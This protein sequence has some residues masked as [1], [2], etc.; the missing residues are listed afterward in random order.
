M[1]LTYRPYIRDSAFRDFSI[2][3]PSIDISGYKPKY[4]KVDKEGVKEVKESPVK[5]EIQEINTEARVNKPPRFKESFHSKNDFI[6]TMI[7][8]YET[9][10]R[11]KGINP[12]FAKSLVAQDGLESAWGSKP[13]GRYNFGGIKG[14]GTIKKTREVINGNNIYLNDSFKDFNSLED[15]ANYK[16]DLL[17]NSRYKVFSGGVNDF[18]SKVHNGGYATDPNYSRILNN[19]ISSFKFGGVFKFQNGGIAEGKEWVKN[20]YKNRRKL[21]KNNIQRTQKVPLPLTGS[22]GYNFLIHNMDLTTASV[23]PSKL[24]SNVHGMYSPHGRRIY[25]ETDSPSTAI[26][27]WVHSSIPDPQVKE[28]E[29]IK[30]ILGNSFYDQKEVTPDDYLDDP[31]EIYSRLMQLRYALNADPN[32]IFT[33]EEIEALKKKHIEKEM[34]INKTKDNR[35][36]TTI[37]N[38]DG[39]V[40]DTDSAEDSYNFDLDK[41]KS[42]RLYDGENTFNIL[43]RYSTDSIRRMLNDVA[44]VP[45]KKD[46]TLYAQM[47]LKIPK[48]QNPS[49]PI[50][51]TSEPWRVWGDYLNNEPT[52]SNWRAPLK[53]EDKPQNRYIVK[54]SYDKASQN[55]YGERYYDIVKGRVKDAYDALIRNGFSEDDAKRLQEPLSAISIKETGWRLVDPN[56]NYWGHLING[57]K[58]AY[59]K[60]KED[61]WDAWIKNLNNLYGTGNLGGPW[62]ESNSIEDFVNKINNPELDNTL[63]SQ[64]EYDE[65]NK[66]M[67]KQGKSPQYMHAPYWNNRN[68]KYNEEVKDIIDR[69]YG[70]YYME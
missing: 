41:S 31:R 51:K 27:E 44:Q 2:K 69:Y 23:D 24:P 30:S 26:H 58:K 67:I 55:D 28:I 61:S 13:S 39:K 59:Y 46:S 49:G 36:S 63:H 48:F 34:L 64:K 6:S 33:N 37:F 40:I 60:S 53:I 62:W 14:K 3:R 52:D 17:N 35:T 56:N 10:L 32:H 12:D 16:V 29:R 50:E 18:A 42:Y 8:I 20:W 22:F 25:L 43:D 5:S 19:I 45:N 54:R 66:N 70:Y 1:E 11:K 15:Y 68:K 65:Y 4:T 38:K 21:I 9:I 7:P 57:G 47:G